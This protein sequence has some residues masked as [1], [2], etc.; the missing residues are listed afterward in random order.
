M[1]VFVGR[2]GRFLEASRRRHPGSRYKKKCLNA[3]LVSPC[4]SIC[5]RQY[6]LSSP[7]GVQFL[8]ARFQMIRALQ[9]VFAE[10]QLASLGPMIAEKQ[11]A[12]TDDR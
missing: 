4:S 8:G 10:L 9:A 5:S 12:R 1:F 6:W 3:S 7:I 2:F 11:L